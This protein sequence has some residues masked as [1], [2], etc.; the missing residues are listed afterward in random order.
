MISGSNDISE[1][2][3]LNLLQKLNVNGWEEPDINQ[4]R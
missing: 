4:P 3:S 2:S 1:I